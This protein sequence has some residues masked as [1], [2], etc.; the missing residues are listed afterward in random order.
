MKGDRGEGMITY[1]V[2]SSELGQSTISEGFFQGWPN[3]PSMEK[4]REILEMS[5]R[6]IVA[7]D[8]THNTIVGFINAISDGVLSAYIP[9]LEVVPKYQG[10]GIGRELIRMMLDELSDIYM[11]DLNCDEDLQPFYTK[12][13]MIKSQGMMIRNYKYQAGR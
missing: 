9:L 3:P 13:G 8:E 4:H 2:Y 12:Q 6:S 7:I 5:Y 1:R 10:Q 11:V